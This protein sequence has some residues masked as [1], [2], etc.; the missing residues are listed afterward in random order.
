MSGTS[1]RRGYI[2]RY[3]I[4]NFKAKAGS[5]AIGGCFV[6]GFFIGLLFLDNLSLQISEI[7]LKL[8][9]VSVKENSYTQLFAT[10]F[11]AMAGLLLFWFLCGF[12]AFGQV[13]AVGAVLLQGIGFG[14]MASY[15]YSTNGGIVDLYYSVVLIPRMILWLAIAIVSVK[16]SLIMSTSFLS[17]IFPNLKSGQGL[18]V[19]FYCIRFM[20]LLFIAVGY[21]LTDSAI[22]RIYYL[23]L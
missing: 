15:L 3:L 13:F 17:V 5:I 2:K 14:I 4:Y 1:K 21:A 11:V 19:R 12:H 20:L 6:L 7:L 23:F 22:Q 16:Q 10:S 9:S 8:C 18:A